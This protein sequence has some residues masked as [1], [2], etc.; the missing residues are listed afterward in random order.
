SRG[1][2][3]MISFT[4][5]SRLPLSSSEKLLKPV[6]FPPGWAKLATNPVLTGSDTRAITMG[7]VEVAR[8]AARDAWVLMATITSTLRRTSSSARS[9]SGSLLAPANR[10][11]IETLRP[12][13]YPRSRS[14]CLRASRGP[15][16][17]VPG[18]ST[19]TRNT[20]GGGWAATSSGQAASTLPRKS[21]NSLRRPFIVSRP[22][23]QHDLVSERADPPLYR[24]DGENAAT[25][26]RPG[27]ERQAFR[28]R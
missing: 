9:R 1:P 24:A 2:V 8:F 5:A 16:G 3:G 4:T 22:R 18:E 28:D 25:L 12:S 14:P 13:S 15:G 6:M 20:R 26:E 23:G 21:T 11:S 10:H 17:A 19:P 27:R 7:I